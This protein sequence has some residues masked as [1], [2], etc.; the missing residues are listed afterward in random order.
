MNISG[1]HRFEATPALRQVLG[2][3]VSWGLIDVNP[4]KQGIDNPQRRHTEKRRVESRAALEPLAAELGPH[5]GPP[6]LFAA[7]TGRRPGECTGPAPRA[8]AIAPPRRV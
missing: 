7:G 1:G 4:A 6:V 2:R 3:A 8:A 5:Y